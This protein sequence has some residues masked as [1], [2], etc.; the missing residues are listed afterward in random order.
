M[1]ERPPG[2]LGAV[3]WDP[4]LADSIAEWQQWHRTER[5]SSPHT[6]TAY[7]TDLFQFFRFLAQHEGQLV[8]TSLLQGLRATDFRSWLSDLAIRGKNASSRGRALSSLRGFYRWLEREKG[9]VNHVV[10]G[11][12]RPKNA[13]PLPRA[14]ME[15]EMDSF[16]EEAASKQH[17]KEPQW[18]INRD[19]AVLLLLYGCGL[20]ISEALGLDQRDWPPCEMSLKVRGKGNK[21]RLVPLLPYVKE[22]VDS[23]LESCPLKASPDK[24]GK[25]P[26][27]LGLQGK[28]LSPR[29]IQN[30]TA[31]LRRI[32]SLPE[33]TT[34]HALRHSF[35]THLLTKSGDLRGVQELLG[36]ASLSSTQRYT[37]LDRESLLNTFDQ[38][39]PE[40]K[41]CKNAIDRK[42]ES[43]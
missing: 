38:F 15:K 24:N 30:K 22:A 25:R 33:K 16:F 23:Y 8:S 43:R 27:F 31:V 7:Q 20:R 19:H 6:L 28:R 2:G 35:A 39:H 10:Q 3:P 32:L 29:I 11:L 14:L 9:V 37:D 36:H 18:V 4:E 41:K 5:R 26:L 12:R 1:K 21:E 13:P 42:N 34:P 17:P 40:G